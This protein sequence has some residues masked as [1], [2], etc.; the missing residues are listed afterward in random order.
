MRSNRLIIPQAMR[1]QVLKQLHHSHAGMVKMKLRARMAVYWPAMSLEIEN[2]VAA[3][4][5]CQ[6]D[7]SANPRE[8]MFETKK[9][10][11]ST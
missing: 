7:R 5:L 9:D 3:C 1:S 10:A 8:P 4:Q 2:F 6:R 11:G